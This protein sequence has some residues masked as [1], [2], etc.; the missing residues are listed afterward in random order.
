VPDGSLIQAVP[1]LLVGIGQLALAL[2]LSW[3]LPTGLL[4]VALAALAV[5]IAR[6][7]RSTAKAATSWARSSRAA[8]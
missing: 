3:R 4:L 6:K 7:R 5:R 8:S 1:A 2:W